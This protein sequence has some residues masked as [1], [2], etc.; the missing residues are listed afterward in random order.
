MHIQCVEELILQFDPESRYR[1]INKEKD[2]SILGSWYADIVTVSGSRFL[3]YVHTKSLYSTID[4]IN[5]SDDPMLGQSFI[6]L[7]G[8]I[9]EMLREHYCLADWRIS[10][11]VHPFNTVTFGYMQNHRMKKIMQGIVTAYQKRFLHAQTKNQEEVRLWELEE[12]INGLKRKNLGGVSPTETLR[13]LVWSGI[14]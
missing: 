6:N 2:L 9:L 12:D 7:R 4:L 13:Q 10:N 1:T 11:L 8:K 14:N 5:S 3:L